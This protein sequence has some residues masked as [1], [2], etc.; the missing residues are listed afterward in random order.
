M[1]NT[2]ARAGLLL[3]WSPLL[4]A[5]AAAL[6]LISARKGPLSGGYLLRAVVV[7]IIYSSLAVSFRRWESARFDRLIQSLLIAALIA[8]GFFWSRDQ[9]F[10]DPHV[11]GPFWALA[12]QFLSAVL[13][14]FFAVLS[15]LG[16]KSR[17]AR[18]ED[19]R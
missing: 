16:L 4:F 3:R 19:A 18:D 6:L 14:V 8:G 11:D 7:G 12:G 1:D 17:G 13:A 2:T 10:G 15:V 9:T 5:G